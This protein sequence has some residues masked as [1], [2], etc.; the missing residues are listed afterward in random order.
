MSLGG[1]G[2]VARRRELATKYV[3]DCGSHL[4]RGSDSSHLADASSH[5]GE[6][7]AVYFVR[8]RLSRIRTEADVLISN[9]E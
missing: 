7:K 6:G 9:Q 8:N 3:I 4:S 1:F 2:P 5:A